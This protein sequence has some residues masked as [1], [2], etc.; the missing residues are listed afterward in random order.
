MP[1]WEVRA[2]MIAMPILAVLAAASSLALSP[3]AGAQEG[4]RC[5]GKLATIV[6]TGADDDL[7]GT[8]G[9]D[10]I[11]GGR[12]DDTIDGGEGN[13]I[14]CGGRGAD[15]LIGGPG[16][17]RIIG[18]ADDDVIL[19]GDGDDRLYGLDGD[20]IL[21]GNSG[22]D[23]LW[24]SIGDDA[25]SGGSGTDRLQGG[26]GTD[27]CWEAEVQRQCET[28]FVE[29]VVAVADP[30]YDIGVAD[31]DGDSILDVYTSN[32]YS[33]QT[34]ATGD[35]AG[36]FTDQVD[37]WGFHQEPSVPGWEAGSDNPDPLP[38]LQIYWDNNRLTLT[39]SGVD[40]AL[41]SG[42]LVFYGSIT[43]HDST[44]FETEVTSTTLSTGL[45]ETIVSFQALKD[46]LVQIVPKYTSSPVQF[47]LNPALS[48]ANVH[49]GSQN[50]EATT[51]EFELAL[52]DRHAYA[53]TDLDTDGHLD[54]AVVRGGLRGDMALW[55]I[56]FRD[57]LLM[58]DG[59]NYVD[60]AEDRAL[61]KGS[62]RG[63]QVRWVD[64]NVDGRLDLSIDCA[65]TPNQLH[66]QEPDGTFTDV[67]PAVG[68]D[69]SSP[70]AGFLWFDPDLDGDPDQLMVEKYAIVLYENNEGTFTPKEL[71]TQSTGDK[72]RASIGLA[73]R[74]GDGDID[75]FV[76]D[77][78]GNW[79]LD[80]SEGTL[81]ALPAA[82]VGLPEASTDAAWVDFDN[83]GLIDLHTFPGGMYQQQLDG[84]FA[85]VPQPF[86]SGAPADTR[87]S[88][89]W[90]DFDNDGDRDLLANRYKDIDGN[91]L[92]TRLYENFGP[93]NHW[94]EIN[95]D[96]SSGNP[97][98]IGA[99]VTITRTGM[100]AT[101]LV[102]SADGSKPSQGHYRLY[103]GLGSSADPVDIEIV[104]PDGS[105]QA[106]SAV[107]VDD[108]ITIAK[109]VPAP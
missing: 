108:L 61:A 54:V 93:T 107:A 43:V 13:D 47:S 74:D 51:S 99:R 76:A 37:T 3:E 90:F 36:G 42:T 95:L 44:D 77:P 35:G 22:N 11:V 80:S 12:G 96:G 4:P 21:D 40:P 23:H 28:Q 20:D 29:R 57:E 6:G 17:D 49:L 31:F 87:A 18:N 75:V 39:T 91:V 2:P 16:D 26:D 63:R 59:T 82:S 78:A 14:I 104:W 101:D 68:L 50:V 65:L 92:P 79:L 1:K 84:T 89:S 52:D 67:A 85:S 10:V 73:D 24:G 7:V 30:D 62:C 53:F 106:L 88:L 38:G 25:L 81:V 97:Q 33:R 9:P 19:G 105:I 83:D 46:G 66:R 72:K 60:I 8:A 86:E 32:H 100:I 69:I 56:E 5:N 71:I 45:E 109:T 102:G 58:F 41:V 64:Y 34:L 70:T 94:L 48:L 98:A 15:E 55:P 103:F 27:Q